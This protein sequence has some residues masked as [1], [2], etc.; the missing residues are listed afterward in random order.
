MGSITPTQ[1]KKVPEGRIRQLPSDLIDQIAAGEVIERPASVLK[2]LVENA[3]DAG[4]GRIR[5]EIREGGAS[6]VAV[7]DD[8]AGM[9]PEEARMALRRHAT[10]VGHSLAMLGARESDGGSLVT[11]IEELHD[12]VLTGDRDAAKDATRRALEA[13]VDPQTLI[14]DAMTPAMDEVGRRFEE[15]EYFVPELLLSARAMKAALELINPL[16]SEAGGS[17]QGLHRH[18]HRPGRPPRHRKESRIGHAR[19][20]GL[21]R[22]RPGKRCLA[23]QVRGSRRRRRARTS[24]ASRPCSR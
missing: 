1:T 21:R 5:V 20:R 12:A 11:Q 13:G 22:R 19:G 15:E 18:R 6:L 23:R 10:S 14:D 9:T 24:W 8:G 4:A 16:L 2:E 3:L 7:T 17:T